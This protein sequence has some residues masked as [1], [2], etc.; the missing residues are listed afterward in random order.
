MCYFILVGF[1]PQ[2]VRVAKG[3]LRSVYH[4]R[5]V[6][7]PSVVAALPDGWS[8]GYLSDGTCACSLYG[9]PNPP[10]KSLDERL[11]A[12]RRQ[13]RKRGWSDAKIERA[14]AQLRDDDAHP[15]TL[16]SLRGRGTTRGADAVG[17][18]SV[19]HVRSRGP[20]SARV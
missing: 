11:A 20:H 12:M 2:A 1:R 5:S 6:E 17:G 10:E 18:A 9:A 3:L 7:N 14:L 19:M 16:L 4:L 8:V 15:S 13:Y